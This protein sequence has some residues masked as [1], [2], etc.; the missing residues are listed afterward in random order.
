MTA[1][2]AILN[3]TAVALA[4]DS[5][6][7]LTGPEGQK[8]YDSAEKIF[9]LSRF[10]P[11][12]L[13][14]YNN[15]EFMNAPLEI[16]ARKFRESITLEFDELIQV[17]PK[18]QDFLLKFDHH[19]DDEKEHFREL[20][21]GEM[22]QLQTILVNHM[23][24]VVASK[25]KPASG[26]EIEVLT[27]GCVQR[28]MDAEENPIEDFLSDKTIKDFSAE[29][30]DLVADIAKR[31]LGSF[32]GLELPT[33]LL[34]ALVK[35][36]FS[37]VK[38]K[39]RSGAYTGFVF[40][41]FGRKELFPSLYSVECDGIYF[42]EFRLLN[43][44]FIDIDRRGETAAIVPFAQ[45]DMPQRFILGIDEDFEQKISGIV[46]NLIV[47]I[48]DQTPDTFDDEM[49][50]KVRIAASEYFRRGVS[51]LKRRSENDLESVVNHLS[52]KELSEVAYSLVELTSRKRRYSREMETVGGP[53]DVAILTRN[54]G[55][56]WVRRKH[57]F[58]QELNPGYFHR[59]RREAG[60]GS[61]T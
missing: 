43:E 23:R 6:A 37:V 39:T 17:W 27:D 52:K 21:R 54:E 45:K 28:R 48:M 15:A 44:N 36:M 51:Q 40:A 53:I 50:S 35:M 25:E 4:A 41:G 61:E 12:G 59:L 18:F 20:V 60:Y 46:E 33:K 26:K 2:I 1:E 13:M 38:S 10:Q 58:T 34:N 31:D 47:Q 16:L 19:D 30:G 11:I 55:F 49:A 56:I 9:E 24:A 5:I 42:G 3:R 22:K 14:I 32:F 29:Y 7:T 57:Y 8:T